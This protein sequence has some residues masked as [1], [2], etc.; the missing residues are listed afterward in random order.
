MQSN[1]LF[2]AN[3]LKV[4]HACYLIVSVHQTSEH[5]VLCYGLK[6]LKLRCQKGHVLETVLLL[7]RDSVAIATYK[8]Q[9][10]IGD[11]F[12]VSRDES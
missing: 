11:L 2:S 4:V 9:H 10:L 1:K 6:R 12:I 5:N 7:C 3:K 8:R